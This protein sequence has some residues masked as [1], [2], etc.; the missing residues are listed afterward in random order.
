MTL[1]K[2]LVCLLILAAEIVL[3]VY[4]LMLY[5]DSWTLTGWK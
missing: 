5:L 1:R 2:F 3:G 4:L